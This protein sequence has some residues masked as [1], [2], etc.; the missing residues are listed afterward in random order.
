[1]TELGIATMTMPEDTDGQVSSSDGRPLDWVR[2]RVVDEA[3]VDLRQGETGRLVVKSASQHV[4]YLGRP[5][6]YAG[7]F[8]AG[9]FDTGDLARQDKRGYIRI[10]GRLKDLI[11]R[12]GENIPVG[13]VEKLL[14]THP[15]VQDVAVVGYPDDRLGERACA[16]AVLSPG[17]RFDLPDSP[18]PPYR[19]PTSAPLP[20]N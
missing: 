9:W 18:P 4:G 11:I 10:V 14:L 17:G 8:S 6:L 3:G 15:A 1:M 20:P 2:V 5:D 7:C 12:G 19:P 13:E 16:L